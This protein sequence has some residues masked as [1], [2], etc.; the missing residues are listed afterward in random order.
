[1]HVKIDF[2]PAGCLTVFI[3]PIAE[4]QI[5]KLGHCEGHYV[6]M[7]T[8][9]EEAERWILLLVSGMDMARMCKE[10]G[11]RAHARV[12][13]RVAQVQGEVGR[14]CSEWYGDK[15]SYSLE[16]TKAAAS[17]NITIVN[18]ADQLT[19]SSQVEKKKFP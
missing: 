14:G 13:E 17:I 4:P 11:S 2:T 10:L 15:S 6:R 19:S 12:Q 8:C 5:S 9:R 3:P 18:R 7:F 16:Y 1:M